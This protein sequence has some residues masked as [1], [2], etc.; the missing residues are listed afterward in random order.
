MS[1]HAPGLGLPV[2]ATLHDYG[3]I[4]N[5]HSVALVS[6]HG[7]IDWLCWPRFASPSL[8][9]RILDAEMGGHLAVRPEEASRS[10]QRYLPS[11]NVLETVFELPD[12]RSLTVTD[13]MPVEVGVAEPSSPRLLRALEATRGKV[14][15]GAELRP[16][17]NYGQ[18]GP[19]WDGN[20]DRWIGRSSGG[21]VW[22]AAPGPLEPVGEGLGGRWTVRPGTRQFLQ[23]GWDRPPAELEPPE[24]L[25]NR[26]IGYWRS[27]VGAGRT[28]SSRQRSSEPPLIERSELVLKL[29]S[30]A[31]SGAFVAAPTTSLPEWPGGTRNWDYRY[32]W[33]RDA[34]FSAQTLLS[35]GHIEEAHAYL[36]W[37]TA[38]LRESGPRPL[39]VLYAAHGDPDLSE[40][41]LPHLRGFLDSRPVRVGNGAA[42]QFQLDIF[43][44]LL[45]AAALLAQV[46]PDARGEVWPE[47]AP[48]AEIIAAQWAAPDRSIWE[49]RGPPDHYVHSKVMAWVG[50]DR[51][52]RLCRLNHDPAGAERWLR[53]AEEIRREVLSRGVDPESGVLRQAFGNARI[54]AAN[55]R[56]PMVGFLPFDDPRIRATIE[57]V[58]RDL[59]EGPFVYRY[60]GADGLDGPEGSFLPCGFWL[61]LCLARIGEKAR[62]HERLAGLAEAAGPLGLW[63]E[64]FDPKGRIPLGNFPQAFSHVAYLRALEALRD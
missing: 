5:L 13:F 31:T 22:V 36:R 50:L 40:R 3:A 35:L 45:D 49:I 34:A 61:V 63:P 2:P 38:R 11:T 7:S 16:R 55:L 24:R 60:R 44:E 4:G 28:R 57:R 20:D 33:I 39:R 30:H 42:D 53:A 17:F 46:D 8:L 62:A 43:G 59:S 12:G 9:A 29:L 58:E 51:A 47:L 1:D 26:T 48:A 52:A 64:E 15:V 32:V 21:S 10:R 19:D 27:W 18:E 56:I 25:L 54:D 41:T 23:F 37:I 6:R 14:T